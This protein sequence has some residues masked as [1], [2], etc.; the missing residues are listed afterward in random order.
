MLE[1][2]NPI[3]ISDAA[4][5]T[6]VTKEAQIKFCVELM[7]EIILGTI[8]SNETIWDVNTRCFSLIIIE[9]L[10]RLMLAGFTGLPITSDCLP[11]GATFIA[12]GVVFN[13]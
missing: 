11:V 4:Q 5:A 3:T 6:M 12:T 13:P 2:F 1:D 10:V 9:P 7:I 8:A